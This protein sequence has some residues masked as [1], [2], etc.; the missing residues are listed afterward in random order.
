M[1]VHQIIAHAVPRLTYAQQSKRYQGEAGSDS[2]KLFIFERTKK[3]CKWKQGDHV[4]YK[5]QEYQVI[6]IDEEL[7][8]VEWDGLSACIVSIWADGEDEVL[9]VHPNTLKRKR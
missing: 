2:H 9:A 8:T 1:I 3:N 6:F 5:K 4:L 7:K